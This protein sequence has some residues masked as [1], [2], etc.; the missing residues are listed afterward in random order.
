MKVVFCQPSSVKRAASGPERQTVM[1]ATALKVRGYEV[2]IG[3]ILFSPVMRAEETTLGILARDAGLH[4]AALYMPQRFNLR[5]CVRAFRDFVSELGVD[6]VCLQSYRANIVGALA[7]YAPTVALVAGWTGQNWKV[8]IY[9]WIE[10]ILLKRHSVVAIV[11]PHQ[12][13]IVLRYSVTSHQIQYIP[14][15]IDV[16]GI[17]PAYERHS[18]REQIG[19]EGYASIAGIIGRL[20]VE[21][22]HRYALEAFHELLQERTQVCLLIVGEGR[23]RPVLEKYASRIG[24]SRHVHFLG[25]RADAR[26]IIGALDLMILPSLTEGIPNVILEA[27]AYKTPVVATA[28]GGVLELVKDSETGWLVPRRNPQALA[29]AIREAL[30]NPEE[31]RRRAEN[32][33]RHLLANFTVEKQVDK[34]EQALQTAVENWRIKRR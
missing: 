30:S 34:W 32:A 2:K 13:E 8:R 16:D 10:K 21:K 5:A 12:R 31:A 1:V 17:P 29:Q 9:E 20:S 6:V 14:T 22:G 28:V 23:E 26:Q 4:V 11:S 19:I 33:Y 25:E 24:I 7:S 3:I 18:L 27:F 15:A